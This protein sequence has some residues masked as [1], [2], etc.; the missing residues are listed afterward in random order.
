MLDFI[1]FIIDQQTN[2]ENTKKV[3]AETIFKKKMADYAN[4]A[5]EGQNEVQQSYLYMSFFILKRR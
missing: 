2:K 4:S 1:S 3:I 5:L